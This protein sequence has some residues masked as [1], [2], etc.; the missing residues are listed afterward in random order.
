MQLDLFMTHPNST[1]DASADNCT[2]S[3]NF[4]HIPFPPHVPP[5]PQY[6]DQ[7]YFSRNGSPLSRLLLGSIRP[8]FGIGTS[9]EAHVYRNCRRN[10]AEL[11]FSRRD[12]YGHFELSTEIEPAELRE[13]ALR[14]L[15]AAH[16]IEIN[17]SKKLTAELQ[18]KLQKGVQP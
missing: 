1:T 2:Q 9:V 15:D 12:K 17:P 3:G 8:A 16:D 10:N 14:L 13:L 7:R 11:V 5:E 4:I 6:A 18:A